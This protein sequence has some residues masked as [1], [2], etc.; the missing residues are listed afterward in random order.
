MQY[1]EFNDIVGEIYNLYMPPNLYLKKDF[2]FGRFLIKLYNNIFTFFKN[3]PSIHQ[4][5]N[6]MYT[7]LY[8]YLLSEKVRNFVAPLALLSLS[9][10]LPV[11]N[12]SIFH[13]N[14]M[15]NNVETL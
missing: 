12:S 7:F 11:Q 1:H 5:N 3:Y 15:L 10:F 13:K 4:S 6:Q 14:M 2:F 9:Q 8:C